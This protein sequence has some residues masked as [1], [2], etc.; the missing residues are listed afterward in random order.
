[1][2]FRGRTRKQTPV[3]EPFAPRR[4][5]PAAGRYYMLAAL[6]WLFLVHFME[7]VRVGNAV[8]GCRWEKWENWGGGAP[9]RVLLIA[10]PQLQDAHTYPAMPRVLQW[11]LQRLGDNYLATNY[12][13]IQ[14]LLD[15]DTTIFLG[16]LFDGGRDWDDRVWLDEYK[17]FNR[18]FPKR[19][20]RRSYRGLPGNHDIGFQNISTHTQH[21]FAAFFGDANEAFDLGNH[22]FLLIDTILL[23]HPDPAVSSAARSFVDGL[24]EPTMPRILL[25][26]VPLFRDPKVETCAPGRE[27]KRPFPLQ[28][29][30]QYQTVIDYAVTLDLWALKPKMVFSGDDH[31]YCDTTHVDYTD[32][33][34]KLAREISCKT[35]SM[36]NG[37]RSPG[38]HL[39]SLYNP[40]DPN[41]R[42]H[43][44]ETFKTEMCLLPSPYLGVKVYVLAWL[45]TCGALLVWI[46]YPE[47]LKRRHDP[48]PRVY[49]KRNW[50]TFAV[51]FG[52]FNLGLWVLLKMY[53]PY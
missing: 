10:D 7:R 3:V 23:S 24:P 43:E 49:E 44:K 52:V 33:S 48:F 50:G 14:G 39:L 20:N 42:Y 30:F 32:N 13:Y 34:I 8:A 41:P 40:Y 36:T 53:F 4:E 38:V 5:R 26:H 21:R 11:V 17:R 45:L 37:I 9:H 15:P 2:N 16:D 46:V 18:I 27:L 29:G 1:M 6:A 35:M 19:P 51:H 25:S 12:R 22:T 31:D 28:K 47:A